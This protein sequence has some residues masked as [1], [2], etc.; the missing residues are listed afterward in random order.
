MAMGGKKQT[1]QGKRRCDGSIVK[2]PGRKI[3]EA[4]EGC[5]RTEGIFQSALCGNNEGQQQAG[6]E[7]S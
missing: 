7:S 3:E 1:R 5:D 6:N 4:I 2:V